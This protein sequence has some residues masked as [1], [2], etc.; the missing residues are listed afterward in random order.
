[1]CAPCHKADNCASEFA[2][3]IEA[4][5]F[6]L[7]FSL[8][9]VCLFI[10][11]VFRCMRN[12]HPLSFPGLVAIFDSTPLLIYVYF[13]CVCVFVPSSSAVYIKATFDFYKI[14]SY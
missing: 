3:E 13:A 7:C 12:V 9:C 11:V 4:A 8:S 10:A 5:F 14:L 2:V 6:P 1:M